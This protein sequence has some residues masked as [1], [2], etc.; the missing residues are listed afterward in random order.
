MTTRRQVVTDEQLGKY[1]SKEKELFER[2]RFGIGGVEF[3]KTMDGLQMLLENRFPITGGTVP[4]GSPAKVSDPLKDYRK[5]K[6]LTIIGPKEWEK[7]MMSQNSDNLNPLGLPVGW[8]PQVLVSKTPKEI[9]VRVELAKKWG[10]TVTLFLD[11]P[12]VGDQDTSL[13][14]QYGWWGVPHDNLG[15]GVVRNDVFW[16]NWFIQNSQDWAR[17]ASVLQPVWKIKYELPSWSTRKDWEKQK[18]VVAEHERLTVSTATSDT[19]FLN[20]MSIVFGKKL[21]PATYARTTTIYDGLPLGV[22]SYDE[23][24][25][26]R[27]GWHPEF[28]DGD[29]GVAVEEVL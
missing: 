28:V 2:V 10:T 29:L 20:M 27:G 18:Q 8:C 6:G 23:G 15:P 9:A 19:L 5:I 3:G 4:A 24:V 1:A 17:V 26:V 25:D 16:S 12:K 22:H 7:A 21:R 13:L 14:N 11:L